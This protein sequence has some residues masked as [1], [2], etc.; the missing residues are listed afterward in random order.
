MSD[1]SETLRQAQAQQNAL[2]ANIQFEK[3]LAFFQQV[4]PD[5]YDQYRHYQPAIVR[6]MVDDDGHFN[7]VDIKTNQALYPY[8]PEQYLREAVDYYLNAPE[9]YVLD[10]SAKHGANTDQDIH[11]KNHNAAIEELKEVSPK[12]RKAGTD[13]PIQFMKILG[14]GSGYHIPELIERLNIQN[15]CIV[16]P[17]TDCF[18]SSLYCID[19]Q[20]IAE[21]FDQDNKTINLILGKSTT[22]Y[23]TLVNHYIRQIGDHNA[24][25]GYVFE[26]LIS[27]E[28]KASLKTF[29][30]Q[31]PATL[32]MTGYFDD[33]QVSIAHTIANL[34]KRMPILTKKNKA[35]EIT[36]KTPVFIIAN[37]PSLD[38]AQGLLTAQQN[39][40]LIVSCGTALGS[41]QKMGIKPDIHIEME[42]TRPVYEWITASTSQEFRNDIALIALNTVHPDVFDLF[43][44]R[45]MAMK[46]NDLGTHYV[47]RFAG[48]KK[49]FIS[50]RS[51]NPT[52]ANAAIALMANMGFKKLYFFGLDLGFS[53]SGQHHSSHSKHYDIKKEH[54]ASL[55]LYQRDAK[56]TTTLPGN[57]GDEIISNHIYA[58]AREM[59]SDV[60]R[61]TPGLECH[62]A[63]DGVLIDGAKP[64]EIDDIAIA[65]SPIANKM[66]MVDA[67]IRPHFDPNVFKRAP[68]QQAVT[69]D[70]KAATETISQI[71]KLFSEQPES[72]AD[73]HQLLTRQHTM[74]GDLKGADK[75]AHTYWLLRG[76]SAQFSHLLAK[77]LY[78]GENPDEAVSNFKQTKAHYLNYL[79][80]ARERI[81]Y[82]LLRKDSR[83]RN[84]SDKV[85]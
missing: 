80:E 67:L 66:S 26:H 31:L 61:H 9:H 49:P 47:S 16:E 58:A 72:I 85:K 52:V 40:A 81:G 38:K 50:L 17:S 1:I 6:P 8:N 70:F 51:C 18:Y 32:S 53:A 33:E 76:S 57:R 82:Q 25:K 22:E 4:L 29:K 27:N 54:V 83:S 35:T 12:E 78:C 24:I 28:M 68:S 5:I 37:G 79:N 65:S 73:C 45:S 23:L 60:I 19:W 15:L 56:N 42:R 69:S 10:F 71:I 2:K 11:F 36:A 30:Q 41:L 63:S 13:E 64:I 84:I 21:Q 48:Q 55:N 43:P 7:L 20:T 77:S 46:S 75:N 74:L 44:K 14:I 34:K 62:N 3:N 39:N 59:V